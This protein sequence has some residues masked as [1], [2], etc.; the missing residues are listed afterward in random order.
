MRSLFTITAWISLI[1]WVSFSQTLLLEDFA[2]DRGMWSAYGGED[3]GQVFSI[4]LGNPGYMSDKGSTDTGCSS[5]GC[6]LY[7]QF[8]P[9]TGNYAFPGGYLQNYIKTGTWDIGTNRLSF[10]V[11]CT[12]GVTGGSD[13]HNVEI[14]TYI[15]LHGDGDTANQGQHYYHF[16]G[17]NV[18]PGQPFYVIL[19]RT[20]QHRVGCCG[21]SPEPEVEDPEWASPT[22]GSQIHYYD[23][24]TRIYFDTQPVGNSWSGNTCKFRDFRFA[25]VANEPDDK[26]MSMTTQYSGPISG[27]SL[28]RYE[29]TWNTPRRVSGGQ[30]YNIRYSTQ[31]MHT[32]GFNSGMDGGTVTGPDGT[33][34]TGA[35]WGSVNMAQ[36]PAMY[37]A[38]Q[39]QGQSLFTEIL[40]SGQSGSGGSGMNGKLTLSGNVTVH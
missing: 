9:P 31:S 18:Y 16:I 7:V 8:L 22:M 20:P 2:T 39:P 23:G 11:T 27:F 5:Q 32:N 15:R 38:I 10:Q 34:Y 35:F 17:G 25:T 4:V 26:V 29:V 40:I 24:L 30:V 13:G 1:P 28:G 19:N 33:D 3:N 12:G 36:V 14:G 21:G 6:G 37:V